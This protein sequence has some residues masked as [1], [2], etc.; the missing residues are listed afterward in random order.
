M[1][2]VFFSSEFVLGEC[3]PKFF[4]KIAGDIAIVEL[5][6]NVPFSKTLQPACLAGLQKKY[7]WFIWT[8]E[9]SPIVDKTN[10]TM[11]GYGMNHK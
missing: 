6:K 5:E 10:F 1:L 8:S 7:S 9:K 3:L 2:Q 11:Y 4:E